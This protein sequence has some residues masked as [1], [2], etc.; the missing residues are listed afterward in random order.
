MD[1]KRLC[2]RIIGI[3]TIILQVKFCAFVQASQVNNSKNKNSPRTFEGIY[4]CPTPNLQ[5]GNQI[6]DL[7][8]I[9][10]ITRTNVVKI[11][12]TDVIINNVEKWQRR[13]DLSYNFFYNKNRKK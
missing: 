12:I 9:Q 13:R 5:G 4:L 3:K 6:M 7:R 10:L 2:H 1:H 8:K 11:L